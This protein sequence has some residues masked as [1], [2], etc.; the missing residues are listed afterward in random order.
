MCGLVWC[1]SLAAAG[2]SSVRHEGGHRPHIALEVQNFTGAHTR[3]VWVQATGAVDDPHSVFRIVGLDTVDDRGIHTILGGLTDCSKPIISPNGRHILFSNRKEDRVYV[4]NWNGTGIRKIANGYACDYWQDPHT[5]TEWAY[6]RMGDGN[7]DNPIWRIQI[8][9]PDIHEL[10]WDKTPI[11]Q[12]AVPWF[13]L[14]EDGTHAGA[15][16]PWPKCGVARLPNKSWTLRGLGCWCS[17]APDNSYRFFHFDGTHDHII[18]YDR[19]GDRHKIVVDGVPALEGHT[20]L[21]PRWTRDVRFMT[22]DGPSDNFWNSEF[23]ILRFNSSFTRI[24]KWLRVTYNNTP[25]YWGDAW[26]QK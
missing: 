14:S 20:T 26:V 12:D 18:M 16:F 10:V 19:D 4:V 23:Y 5:H 8:D 7:K 6:V 11:D 21:Y 17:L 9:D 15:A 25:D 22:L 2:A 3:L 1:L 24:E 13:Q